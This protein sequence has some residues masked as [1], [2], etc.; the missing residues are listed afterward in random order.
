MDDDDSIGGNTSVDSLETMESLQVASETV[1]GDPGGRSAASSSSSD[2]QHEV[3]YYEDSPVLADDFPPSAVD[4]AFLDQPLVATPI[5]LDAPLPPP[6]SDY[7]PDRPPPQTPQ[8]HASPLPPA[9]SPASADYDW[10]THHQP[11]QQQAR[12]PPP[13]PY[14]PPPP[15]VAPLP[16]RRESIPSP[17]APA[18]PASSRSGSFGSSDGKKKSGWARLG[19]GSSKEDKKKSKGKEKEME[20]VHEAAARQQQLDR[21]KDARELRDRE[22][23]ERKEREK[24]K[25]K[26]SGFF[27]G[28]FGKRKSEQEHVAPPTP[29]P[30]PEIR[31]PPPPPTASGALAPNGRYI[32][33]YRLPIHVERAVYRLSHIKLA[34]PRRPLFEQ[35][36]I[37]NLMSVVELLPPHLNTD[38]AICR[39][40]YL[41]IINKPAAPPAAPAPVPIPVPQLRGGPDDAQSQSQPS[42]PQGNPER[43]S[44]REKRT[45]SKPATDGQGRRAGN[46]SAEMPVKQPQFEQQNRQIEQEY[47]SGKQREGHHSPQ[48]WDQHHSPSQHSQPSQHQHR[49]PT[50]VVAPPGD[51]SSSSRSPDRTSAP[52]EM[53]RA[54]SSTPSPADSDNDDEED[55][56]PLG[57]LPSHRE[58]YPPHRPIPVSSY[59]KPDSGFQV[60]SRKVSP[61]IS[62]TSTS[63]SSAEDSIHRRRVSNISTISAGSFDASDFIDAYSGAPGTGQASSSTS[64]V[65]GF[66]DSSPTLDGLA[67]SEEPATHAPLFGNVTPRRRGDS[68]VN[69]AAGK[70]VDSD[71]VRERSRSP[72]L[73]QISP[74][75]DY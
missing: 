54:R 23:K 40:W 51:T 15:I 70:G 36:L 24:E 11:G 20:K 7:P 18:S 72:P 16:E 52:A 43:T 47:G 4:G 68:L 27:G 34:N 14:V 38:P 57:T 74:V 2:Q 19:L 29:S 6:P 59:P 56:R 45:L 48:H 25:E 73:R 21:E 67:P 61:T 10:S 75:G 53:Y 64:P 49:S 26:D 69:L 3:Q 65:L 44:S 33:F 55:D 30:P 42:Q 28:L 8:A 31:T 12:L 35:V 13:Q 60:T 58:S 9:P 41:S 50:V 39:F 1:D 5:D 71:L 63:S 32:N 66:K 46:R 22:E 37:S 62:R 17:P